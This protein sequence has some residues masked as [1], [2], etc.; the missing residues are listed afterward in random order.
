[1]SSWLNARARRSLAHV[2]LRNPL[3]DHELNQGRVAWWLALPGRYGGSIWWD[4]VAGLPG[5]LTGFT[6][7]YGWSPQSYA[8]GA[9]SV[10]LDGAATYVNVPNSPA[11]NPT[12]AITI[13]AWIKVNA[14]SSNANILSKGFT[15]VASPFIQYSL[16]FKSSSPFNQYGLALSISGTDTEV[17][18]TSAVSL[19]VWAQ[20]AVSYDGSAM[21]LYQ[22]GVRD[23]NAGIAFGALST[24]NTPVQIGRWGTQG[25]QYFNGQVAQATIYD[26][27]LSSTKIALDYQLGPQGYPG[28][29]RRRRRTAYSVPSVTPSS[30]VFRKT[31]SSIGTRVGK[32]QPQRVWGGP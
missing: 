8:G 23:S 30:I 3:T 29:L 15:S 22:N 16:K 14:F 26:R 20:L 32:R 10:N 25:S 2:D 18:S 21:L 13:I 17:Y 24:Y 6:A 5:T 27:A 11:L 28:V 19:G 7:G 1:M 31:L 9:G 4:L 12:S